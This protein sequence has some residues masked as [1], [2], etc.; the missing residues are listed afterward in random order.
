[1]K[2]AQ[3]IAI[4]FFFYFSFASPSYADE[5]N[6]LNT[7]RLGVE[8]SE[9][10][11]KAFKKGNSCLSAD[12]LESAINWLSTAKSQC[13]HRPAVVKDIEDLIEKLSIGLMM[14][15]EQCGH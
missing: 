14:S 9:R 1:M 3:T 5:S 11:A 6:C 4:L 13:S 7:Y 12:E 15:V 2:T 8:A 10:A